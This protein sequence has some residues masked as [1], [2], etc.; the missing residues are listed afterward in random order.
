MHG[1]A[2]LGGTAWASGTAII[3]TRAAWTGGAAIV[4]ALIIAAGTGGA[5]RTAHERLS[6]THRTGVNWTARNRARWPGRHAGTRRRRCSGCGRTSTESCHHVRTRRHHG[7]G[8]RLT[9]KI[10]LGRRTQRMRRRSL[11]G[12]RARPHSLRTRRRGNARHTG[13]GWARSTRSGSRRHGSSFRSIAYAGRKRL[14]RSRQNL[15]RSRRG[16]RPGG[17]CRASGHRVGRRRG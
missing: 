6:R 13:G 17:N 10:R 15:T 1:T 9:G 14:S 4:A 5:T 12:R 2:A 16:H 11:R 3:T 7:S 8:L